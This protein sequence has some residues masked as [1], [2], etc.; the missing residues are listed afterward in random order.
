M[1]I[2]GKW[3][4]PCII[5]G[6]VYNSSTTNTKY[7]YMYCLHGEMKLYEYNTK[8][9]HLNIYNDNDNG[10]G[11]Y[12]DNHKYYQYHKLPRRKIICMGISYAD[13]PEERG[14]VYVY[15]YVYVCSSTCH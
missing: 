2:D 7:V 3:F 13:D 12:Y 6:D 4:G 10:D 5:T 15:V 1:D 9:E 8:L 14:Y 11:Y